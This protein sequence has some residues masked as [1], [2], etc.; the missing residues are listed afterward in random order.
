ML[1]LQQPILSVFKICLWSFPAWKYPRNHRKKTLYFIY[2]Q[3]Q[4][5]TCA[6]HISKAQVLHLCSHWICCC[7]CCCLV[8]QGDIKTRERVLNSHTKGMKSVLQHDSFQINQQAANGKLDAYQSARQVT[9][10]L[11]LLIVIQYS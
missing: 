4:R 9:S 7:C 6:N 2:W 5:Y 3:F 10:A 1:A 8:K 11:I